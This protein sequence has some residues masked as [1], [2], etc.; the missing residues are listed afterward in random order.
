MKVKGTKSAVIDNIFPSLNTK[1]NSCYHVVAEKK[2]C[3]HLKQ[4]LFI[5]RISVRV[6]SCFV[7]WT[8]Y[9]IYLGILCNV[10][11]NY[12]VI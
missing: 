6:D 1:Q 12:I 4:V 8:I 10:Y 2:K 11:L 9:V 3:W 7:K 5:F